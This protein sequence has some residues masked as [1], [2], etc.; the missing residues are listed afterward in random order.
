[1][2]SL[3][4]QAFLKSCLDILRNG[5][6]KYDG[7]KAINEFITLIT[8][9]LVEHRI[10]AMDSTKDSNDDKIRI[11]LDCQFTNLYNNYCNYTIDTKIN[12]AHDLFDLLYN[13]ERI[14]DIEDEIDDNLNHIGQ[15]KKR[16]DK[17]ECVIHRFNKYTKTLNKLTD[18]VIDVKSLTSFTKEHIYDVQK[19]VI[20][21]QETFGDIDIEHFTYDAFGNAYEKMIADELGNGSKRNGQYF[22]KRELIKYIID[23]LDVKETDICYDPACGTGGFLLG[24]ASK[25][26]NNKKFIK[27]NIYGQEYLDEVY[28]TLN[29]N[30]LAN[31]F[32]K[33][34]KHISKGD[35][36]RFDN[37]HESVK[38]KFDV[39]GA[40]PPFGLSIDICPKE[41]PINNIKNSVALFLQHI[42]FSLKNEGRAGIVIDR[43]ILNNGTD[44]KNAWEGKLRK[45]LLEKTNITKIINL[46]TG[47]FKHT[48]FATSVI[49]FTKGTPTKNIQYIEG[50]FND[51]DK[52]K[53]DKTLLLKEP[54]ILNIKTI[55]EKNYSLKFD[56]Y[57]KVQ[58]DNEQDT[59]GWVKLGDIIIH[60]N[61]GEVINKSYFNCGNLKLYSCSNTIINTNYNLFPKEKFTE[62][63]DLLLPRNGSQIPFV[64]IP[65]EKS[66]YTNVVSRIKINKNY[67][68]KYV[69]YYLNLSIYEFIISD[70]EANSIPSYNLTK[71]FDRLIPN[72]PLSHQEEIVKFLDEV[73]QT[74]KI[75]DTIKYMKDKPI[76]NLLIDKNYEGFKDIIFFQE[77]IPKLMFEL[78]NIPKKKNLQVQSIFQS[79]RPQCEIK[80]LGDICKIE[81]GTFS[82]GDIDNN[83]DFPF[84]SGKPDNPVGTHS[85]YSFDYNKYILIIKGGGCPEVLTR[86]DNEH[87]GMGKV[88][89]VKNK[90]AVTDGLYCLTLKTTNIMYEYLFLYFKYNKNSILKLAKF[91]TRLGNITKFSFENF[92]VPVPPLQVQE[93]IIKRIEALDV[94]SS[95]Y[96]QYAQMLQTELDNISDIINNMTT[97]CKNNEQ[98]NDEANDEA[99]DEPTDESESESDKLN[100]E[101]LNKKT[102]KK[103]KKLINKSKEESDSDSSSESE[104]ESLKELKY[105]DEIYILDNTNVYYK[106][107][108]GK[109]GELF[110]TYKNGK[111]KIITKEI[112]L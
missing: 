54:N 99:N 43:G 36:I 1:M 96:N 94:K 71:W 83:G 41:Y 61:A 86:N 19:L 75:E 14:W 63:G 81:T 80:K 103:L 93:E 18:N 20:K 57:F 109:K 30:M 64:K 105:K 98:L 21:I 97:A 84:Y 16:N 7:L 69:Y 62:N 60:D 26:K 35:S 70:D 66:L 68:Y 95:H 72:L 89:L 22:T 23:E 27:N 28:K 100:D 8:L 101:K 88:F 49:F 48:N 55:K 25:Y 74:A 2:D 59:S 10:C 6:S 45:F 67:S 82:S 34:L 24:F 46:P 50:Y 52:G 39:V 13:Y 91:G 11:G 58:E 15:T 79:Y 3:Q 73:Y 33:S 5:D 42:Y 17:L 106:T 37:Y 85:N 108:K 78:E 38:D 4:W 111:L 9:K 110:G 29:F 51:E 53:G 92:K 77:N 65:E 102:S 40:N 31:N 76:F 107:K 90:C 32:D 47:I 12:K 87:V 104:G 56:D 44:K 112:T